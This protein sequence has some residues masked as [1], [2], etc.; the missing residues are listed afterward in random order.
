VTWVLDLEHEHASPSVSLESLK[1]RLMGT[2]AK[3]KCRLSAYPQCLLF[4]D[5]EQCESPQ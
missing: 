3:S 4:G 5:L 2:K 1:D